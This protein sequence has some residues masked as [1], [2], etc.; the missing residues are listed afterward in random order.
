MF[1]LD[2]CARRSATPV[3]A[4]PR[5]RFGTLP[6]ATG[7]VDPLGELRLAGLRGEARAPEGSIDDSEISARG[8]P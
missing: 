3:N 1:G 4:A 5:E 6:L 8:V 2:L 7:L